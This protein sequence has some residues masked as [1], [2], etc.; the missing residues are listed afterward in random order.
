MVV[1]SVYRSDMVSPDTSAT[2]LTL[3]RDSRASTKTARCGLR[4]RAVAPL[5]VTPH[6][7]VAT[8]CIGTEL[9]MSVAH[10]KAS[11][12]DSMVHYG[13]YMV[14]KIKKMYV[15]PNQ[16]SIGFVKNGLSLVLF[17]VGEA[18]GELN[19]PSSA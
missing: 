2:H 18:G 3:E 19:E 14:H 8:H 15:T 1:R 10:T 6:L 17:P 9:A 16:A 4:V 5:P 7:L 12:Q 11:R 13:P